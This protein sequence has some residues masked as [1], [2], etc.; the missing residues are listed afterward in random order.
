MVFDDFI[1]QNPTM[2]TYILYNIKTYNIAWIS[3][4]SVHIKKYE[5]KLVIVIFLQYR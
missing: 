2:L 5:K 3:T 1:D 4:I